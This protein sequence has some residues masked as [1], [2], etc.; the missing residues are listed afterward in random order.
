M[1]KPEMTKNRSTPAA[2]SE[3]SGSGLRGP[4]RVAPS[5]PTCSATTPSAA[6]ARRIWIEAT[7]TDLRVVIFSPANAAMPGAGQQAWGR[8]AHAAVMCRHAEKASTCA[9]AFSIAGIPALERSDFLAPEQ[10]E[11]ND[12]RQRNAEQPEQ[13]A[14]T[15]THV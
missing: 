3:K 9:E 10:R 7:G 5:C 8:S 1:M 15:K 11:K 4:S 12:D 14:F 6:T 2:P 13:C